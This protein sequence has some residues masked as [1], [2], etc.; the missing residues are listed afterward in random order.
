ALVLGDLFN[1]L[2]PMLTIYQEY[3]RN[4][5]FSLQVLAECK[6]R[7]QFSSILRRL[8][9]KPQLNGRTLP[10][11]CAQQARR[12]LQVLEALC[13][14]RPLHH[15]PTSV[16]R[17]PHN[18]VLV[19]D[20]HSRALEGRQ[21]PSLLEYRRDPMGGCAKAVESESLLQS[22]FRLHRL[23]EHGQPEWQHAVRL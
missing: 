1:M 12:R 17:N 22:G 7:D 13:G 19:T 10:G 11:E 15:Q 8:E 14:A 5:H 23:P 18:R 21:S 16:A 9:E 20:R 3:V 6:Q 2:L 4:H